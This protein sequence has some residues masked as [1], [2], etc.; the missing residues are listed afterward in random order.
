M[1]Q[2]GYLTKQNAVGARHATG[3]DLPQAQCSCRETCLCRT[4]FEVSPSSQGTRSTYHCHPLQ[5]PPKHQL[6]GPCNP[7]FPIDPWV[8]HSCAPNPRPAG[9]GH[10]AMLCPVC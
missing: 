1:F 5:L 4:A 3:R 2:L 8:R 9:M 6:P 10:P 7:A